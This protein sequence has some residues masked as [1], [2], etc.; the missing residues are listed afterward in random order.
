VQLSPF[1]ICRVARNPTGN[2]QWLQRA[3]AVVAH[4]GCPIDMPAGRTPR[5]SVTSPSSKIPVPA[6]RR[7]LPPGWSK[8][9]A[10]AAHHQHG[11]KGPE[12]ERGHDQD[13]GERR[14]GACRLSYEGV[15]QRARQDPL[16]TPNAIGA[17]GPR[18]VSRLRKTAAKLLP[19]KADGDP[20]Q[21]REPP[22]ELQRHGDHQQSGDDGKNALAEIKA[23]AIDDRSSCL[24]GADH[25]SDGAGERAQEDVTGQT[26][27]I[28]EQMPAGRSLPAHAGH[29]PARRQSRRTCR[30][31]EGCR[32]SLRGKH[33]IIGHGRMSANR[34]VPARPPPAAASSLPLFMRTR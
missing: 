4:A 7:A 14:A 3:A 27:G 11:R 33:E 6:S 23:A 12:P 15:D 22:E 26:S 21:D 25:L 30:C 1:N 9:D 28:V 32:R 29:V 16:N 24:R 34:A 13:A 19:E 18:T 17:P 5:P 31:N 8:R 2:K 10:D 20:M